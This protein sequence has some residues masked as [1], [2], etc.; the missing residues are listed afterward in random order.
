MSDALHFE[1][2][3]E[4][5]RLVIDRQ[6]RGNMLGLGH[7]EELSGYV[8]EA[9][10]DPG[11][12]AIHLSSRG[13]DFC[14]GRDPQD[15]PENAPKNAVEMRKMLTEPL[16]GVY[17]AVRGAEVPVV[18]SVQG[19]ALGFG[20]ATASVCD[21]TIAADNSRF[22]LPEM[23]NDLPPTL[24][25]CAHIDRSLP[26]SLLWMVYSTGEIDA[27]AA[28]SIGFVSHIVPA[29]DLES[30]TEAFLS[31]LCSRTREAIVTCK[32]YLGGARLMET[33][34]ASSYAGNLLAVKMSSN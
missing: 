17:A 14:R 16:L 11:I 22:S 18:A 27:A 31:Q 29:A 1:R 5:A 23:K 30:E 19:G 28:Q 32:T 15:A 9:G 4:I 2:D 26:K 24:A 12:K 20:C 10:S 6:D 25:M 7:V 3:G 33:A 13:P 8:R 34:N 21:V